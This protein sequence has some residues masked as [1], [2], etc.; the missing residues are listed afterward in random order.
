MITIIDYKV[1][2]LGSVLN[3]I[4][5][6]GGHEI[7]VVEKPEDLAGATKIILPGVGSYDRAV[8]NLEKMELFNP[9]KELALNGTPLLGICL[10]MQL[11]GK[12]SEEG[13]C[14]G[15]GLINAYSRR[16][17]DQNVKVPHM[18]WSNLAIK[19]PTALLNGLSEDS[20]YY[21]VHSYHVV[22]EN[23]SNVIATAK[24]GIEFAAVINSG[25]IWGAQFHPEKSHRFGMEMLKSF[26]EK[27]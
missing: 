25:N 19:R 7:K 14:S 22:C 23:E 20:R 15:L 21:F 3:M 5:K 8:M 13:R 4:R 10:G 11:L 26:L 18:G 12:G 17:P 6:I 2:N 24:H 9:I 16:L 1:V 27:M